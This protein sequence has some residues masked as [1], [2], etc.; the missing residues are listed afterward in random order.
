MMVEELTKVLWNNLAS[1]TVNTKA[2]ELGLAA[3]STAAASSC[4]AVT[5]M[6]IQD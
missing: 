3:W 2:A 1:H 5:V 4:L 6:L